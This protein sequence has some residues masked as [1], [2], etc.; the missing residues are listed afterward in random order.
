MKMYILI[1]VGSKVIR[2]HFGSML[3]AS[4]VSLRA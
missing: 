4:G 2:I 3:V 1:E